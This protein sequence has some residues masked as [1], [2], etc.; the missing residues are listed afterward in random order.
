MNTKLELYEKSIRYNIVFHI[1]KPKN[2]LLTIIR[3]FQK[4]YIDILGYISLPVKYI[5]GCL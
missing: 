2:Q 4:E 3:R 5:T 1:N